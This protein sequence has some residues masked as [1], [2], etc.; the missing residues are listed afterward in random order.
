MLSAGEIRGPSILIRTAYSFICNLVFGIRRY[1]QNLAES[2]HYLHTATHNFHQDL[3]LAVA[4]LA[5][6]LQC[7][8][9]DTDKFAEN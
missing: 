2:I 8:M 3:R 6:R 5:S 7:M 9:I 1:L 4:C